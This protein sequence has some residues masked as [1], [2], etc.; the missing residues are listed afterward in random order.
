M[1]VKER[2]AKL[3]AL[4]EQKN[5]DVYLIPS[6]DNHQSEYVGDYFKS[7]EF[8]T[9]FTGSA[10]TAVISKDTAGLWTDGRYFIQA[11]KEL[12][13][14]GITL[15]KMGQPNVPTIDEYLDT[16]LPEN[17]TLGFDG[18]VISMSD[19][20]KYK[21]LFSYKNIHLEDGY[22]LID[23]IWTER[24][25]MSE[26]PLFLL[27][28]K[29][30]GESTSSKLC[31]LREEMK[32]LGAT[33]H[34]LITLDDI[35]WLLNFR[36]RD[37]AYTP[38][39][40]CYAVITLDAVHLFINENKL[41]SDI[42]NEFAKNSIILHNYNDIYSFTQQLPSDEVVLLDPDRLNY[43]LYN[44]IPAG[45]KKIE[46]TNP[47]LLFKAIKN[48]VEMDNIRI[49]HIKD[50]IAHTKF[51]CWLKTHFDKEIITEL[52]ASDKLEAFRSEQENFLW[53]SFEPI[54]AY[55]AHAAM[56]H[57]SS[58][59][60]TNV[61]LKAGSLFL[62]DTGG[63]YMEGS[64]DITRT[65]A[66]GE[67]HKDLK[68][69]FTNV[70]RGN[71]ALSK[72]KFLYGCTGQ[73]L[74]ILARQFLWNEEKDYNHGTGHGVGYLLSIHE[75]GAR[76]T[77]R[78]VKES[79]LPLEEG[80]LVTDEPGIY[81][82][83]SHGIRLEN[84]LFVRKHTNNIYGQFMCFEVLTFVPFDLDAIEVSM[85]SEEEKQQLNAYHQ[86]VYD[87]VSPHMTPEEQEWLKKYT[88]AI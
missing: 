40:L 86:Q 18:R 36:G 75:P 29:Y 66:L 2:I 12:E 46:T 77:W 27:D 82:E 54:S 39:V 45:I 88:R 65:V 72:A 58:S 76:I 21:E 63:N 71:L 43:A 38:V 23:S 13:G 57:Y 14:S 30:S 9:G 19:G 24:P 69:D 52:S 42:T 6:A 78:T 5:I 44:S 3:R 20:K 64:T 28:E 25:P 8:I 10:G 83:D 15:F 1:N 61:E 4:M 80:M 87:I 7:R 68:T 85:L 79:S 51:M 22:D 53:P 73:T 16:I 32:K 48:P 17:G 62:T 55:G 11:E 84:E 60:E 31:R 81:I 33:S 41:S 50:G 47:C 34:L 37:V 74:D 70:L 35:A 67:I 26:H 56:C 59:E 49:A